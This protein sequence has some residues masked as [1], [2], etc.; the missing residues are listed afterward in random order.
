MIIYLFL[1]L[2]TIYSIRSDNT[3]KRQDLANAGQQFFCG[4]KHK[5]LSTSLPNER[6]GIIHLRHYTIPT[7]K[8]KESYTPMTMLKPVLQ[9]RAE[10]WWFLKFESHLQV[11]SADGCFC[12]NVSFKACS[13]PD[14]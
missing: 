7:I 5:V 6:G 10:R 2:F 14:Q 3:W 9:S 13:I 4:L 11:I 1:S 12:W 8:Q